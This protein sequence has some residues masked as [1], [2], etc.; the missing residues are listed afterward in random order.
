MFEAVT[1]GVSAGGMQALKVVLGAL[2]ESFPLPIAVVQHIEARSDTFLCDYLDR[3]SRIQVK[4]AEDKEPMRSGVAYL[5][6][7]GYHLLIEP[8]RSFSLSVDE[9]VNY[10]RP[11][12]DLL[13][14]SAADVF[15][16]RLIGVIL[17]GANADGAKGLLRI[18]ERGG[19]ALV[20]NPETAEAPYMPRAAIAAGPV[21]E[22]TDLD[23]IAPM[24]IKL[25]ERNAYGSG[26]E[27]ASL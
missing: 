21:D 13:F 25:G 17:T 18:K 5:A 20:Q 3:M 2:P 6:P 4:E 23:L 8:E 14:E 11:S 26:Y 12:I 1:I 19:F 9:K 27:H 22:V 24:L 15:G 7:A 16:R 10:C